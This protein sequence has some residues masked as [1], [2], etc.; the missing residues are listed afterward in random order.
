MNNRIIRLEGPRWAFVI[1]AL[2]SFALVGYMVFVSSCRGVETE[3]ATQP[4][5]QA[6][7]APA[8]A[9]PTPAATATPALDGQIGWDVACLPGGVMYAIYDGEASHAEVLTYYTSFDGPAQL[10]R[11]LDV[12]KKGTHVTRTF[13]PCSQG[14]AEPVKGNPA[15]HCYFD[16]N[17]R[18]F[19]DPRSPKVGEC[20]NRCVPTWVVDEKREYGPWEDSQ[21]YGFTKTKK[22]YKTQRRLVIVYQVNTCTKERKELKRYYES[23]QVEIPCPKH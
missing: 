14:D 4:V 13:P 19:Y 22:C 16:I 18:P 3:T 2:L 11:Q 17:G 15:G 20:R 23:K 6:T 8:V 9:A 12:L 21:G 7:A 1:G 10:G 5:V